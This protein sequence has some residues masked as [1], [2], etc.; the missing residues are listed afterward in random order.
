MSAI[1]AKMLASTPLEMATIAWSNSAAPMARSA[2]SSAASSWTAWVT[3]GAI[4]LTIDS[5]LSTASTS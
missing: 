1:V 5:L 2:P 3:S 4:S